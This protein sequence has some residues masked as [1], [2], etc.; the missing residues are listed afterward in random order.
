ML[1]IIL[2]TLLI[3]LAS[4]S[5]SAKFSLDKFN[6]E[7]NSDFL[8]EEIVLFG[9]K[10]EEKDLIIIFEGT[11]K[12]GNLFTKSKKGLLWINE[13]QEID[14]V[15]SFF[16]IFSTPKYSLNEIFL[17]PT[18]TKSHLLISNISERL[19]QIRTAL[20]EKGLYFEDELQLI[21]KSL[22]IKKFKIPDNISAGDIKVSL[23]EIQ[24]NEVINFSQKKLNI[25]KKGLTSKLEKMLKDQ[26][27]IYT[28]IL[29]VFSIIFSLLSNWLF[30]R[31]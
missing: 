1:K 18:L 23:Y 8:G 12:K 16:A 5:W 27:L 29:V 10:D 6:I 4:N 19:Y 14:K 3:L 21:E 13:K 9:Q 24:N 11:E 31:R 28:I 7:I 26:S 17:L 25:Q 22:F 15:P 30:R 2:S 20:K